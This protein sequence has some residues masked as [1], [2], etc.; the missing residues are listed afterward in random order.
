LPHCVEADDGHAPDGRLLEIPQVEHDDGLQP[1]EDWRLVWVD[2]DSVD[3][4]INH[5]SDAINAAKPIVQRGLL[6][7]LYDEP[8]VSST[9]H[10][11]SMRVKR[12]LRD[13]NIASYT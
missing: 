12:V 1:P 11:N 10:Q 6:H 2:H 13:P 9:L 7:R 4:V 5:G 3:K 8:P